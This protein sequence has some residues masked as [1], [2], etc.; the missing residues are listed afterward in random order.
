M[1][2]SLTNWC[3]FSVEREHIINR[4]G[5]EAAGSAIT[6]Q[7]LDFEP[8]WREQLHHCTNIADFDVSV[9]RT[10]QNRNTA[11]RSRIRSSSLGRRDCMV[12]YL[13]LLSKYA[14]VA[15]LFEVITFDDGAC[16]PKHGP[17]TFRVN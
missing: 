14:V 15:M 6:V 8:I 10:L 3:A 17:L 9:G 12:F 7:K 4:Q 16:L 5:G 11:I 1:P 13:L 2:W